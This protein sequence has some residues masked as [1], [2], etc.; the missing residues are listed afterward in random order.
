MSASIFFNRINL[1]SYAVNGEMNV[2]DV[3]VDH[4][5]DPA[6]MSDFP[7]QSLWRESTLWIWPRPAECLQVGM[8][9]YACT[10]TCRTSAA[11]AM[12]SGQFP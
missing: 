11:A 1:G 2:V 5:D 9:G 6:D 3:L 7:S 10:R 8:C 4:T 12:D